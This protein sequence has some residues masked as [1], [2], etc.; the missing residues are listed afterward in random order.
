MLRCLTTAQLD[1]VDPCIPARLQAVWSLERGSTIDGSLKLSCASRYTLPTAPAPTRFV[2]LW[3]LP[4]G[5]R[6]HLRLLA[7]TDGGRLLRLRPGG[8]LVDT[9]VNIGV[10]C[11]SDCGEVLGCLGSDQHCLAQARVAVAGRLNHLPSLPPP[12]ALLRVPQCWLWL[13]PKLT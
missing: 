10:R 11:G 13:P 4:G 5:P 12:S 7:C 8:S 3:G 6:S 1:P 9:E 2:G